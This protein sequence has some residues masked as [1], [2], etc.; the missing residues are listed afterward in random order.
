MLS[1]MPDFVVNMTVL[2][3]EDERF[4]TM[5]LEALR[6]SGFPPQQLCLELM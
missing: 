4:N 6:E 5:L 2:Q 1:V 3:L